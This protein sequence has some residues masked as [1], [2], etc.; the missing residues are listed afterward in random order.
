MNPMTIRK[1]VS[2]FI[3]LFIFSFLITACTSAIGVRNPEYIKKISTIAV[4]NFTGPENFREMAASAFARSVKD[5]KVVGVYLPHQIREFLAEKGMKNVDPADAE[6]RKLLAS[7]LKVDAIVNGQIVSYMNT[8]QRTSG[9]LELIIRL[10]DV[11]TDAQ[12]YS[13]AVRTDVS[14][15]LTGEDS[16][17]IEAAVDAIIADIKNQFD[18]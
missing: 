17:L 16:E 7:L 4:L 14:G 15:A 10:T 2:G 3:I 11:E 1:S 12:I 9:N 13:A 18:L 8:R 5:L 6:A